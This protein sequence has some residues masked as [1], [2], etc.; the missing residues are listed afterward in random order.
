[1]ADHDHDMKRVYR[2]DRGIE[3]QRRSSCPRQRL[4]FACVTVGIELFSDWDEN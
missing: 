1:M 2:A 4:V 3:G